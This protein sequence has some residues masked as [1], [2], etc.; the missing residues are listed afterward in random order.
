MRAKGL[1][2]LGF[3]GICCEIV[4]FEFLRIRIKWELGS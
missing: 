3:G 1:I 4:R 2:L